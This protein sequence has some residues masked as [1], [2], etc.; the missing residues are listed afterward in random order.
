M[1]IANDY[2]GGGLRAG[3]RLRKRAAPRATPPL[4]QNPRG[5]QLLSVFLLTYYL[6]AWRTSTVA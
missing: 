3:T 4:P 5:Q 1:R 2:V 6:V